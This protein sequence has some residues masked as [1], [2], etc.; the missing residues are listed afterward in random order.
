M[1]AVAVESMAEVDT[2]YWF[3]GSAAAPTV[4]AVVEHAELMLAA[5]YRYYPARPAAVLTGI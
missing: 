4:R 2:V 1:H 5:D 3:E